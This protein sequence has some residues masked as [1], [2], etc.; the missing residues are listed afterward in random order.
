[1]LW[2]PTNDCLFR[3]LTIPYCSIRKYTWDMSSYEDYWSYPLKG[4]FWDAGS[5]F[6]NPKYGVNIGHYHC[7]QVLNGNPWEEFEEEWGKFRTEYD[8]LKL[9]KHTDELYFFNTREE[10]SP[11]LFLR[12]D[13]KEKWHFRH[14]VYSVLEDKELLDEYEEFCHNFFL[15]YLYYDPRRQDDKVWDSYAMQRRFYFWDFLMKEYTRQSGRNSYDVKHIWR[16]LKPFNVRFVEDW[17][18]GSFLGYKEKYIVSPVKLKFVNEFVP[19]KA[20]ENNKGK[21]IIKT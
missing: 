11:I 15:K 1:M 17:K 8:P 16:P 10:H 7:T 19:E 6:H 14:S 4:N 13:L 20:P 2:R 5:T 9:I 12:P 21:S 18:K 3:F